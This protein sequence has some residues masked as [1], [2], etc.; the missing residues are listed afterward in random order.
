M[1]ADAKLGTH[2]TTRCIEVLAHIAATQ[3]PHNL[4]LASHC[5]WQMMFPGS[6]SSRVLGWQAESGP[7]C[8]KDHCINVVVLLL[9]SWPLVAYRLLQR[10]KLL[11]G[12]AWPRALG[13]HL[14]RRPLKRMQLLPKL[15]EVFV[16]GRCCDQSCVGQHQ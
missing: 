12:A 6:M 1:P 10:Y 4:S 3:Q 7:N 5:T 14:K 11:H 9:T 13:H 8:I 2:C 15:G 16:N